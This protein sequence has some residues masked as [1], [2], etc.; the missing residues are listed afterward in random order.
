MTTTEISKKSGKGRSQ[1]VVSELTAFFTVKPGRADHLRAALDRFGHATDAVD[2]DTRLRIGLRELR[3]VIF[4]DD[5]RF[6]WATS[7]ETDWDPYI[8]DFITFVG[9]ATV[10]DFTQH[11]VEYPFPEGA[12]LTASNAE[13]KQILQANQTQ[14]TWFHEVFSARTMPEIFKA[15]KV[16]QAFQ[17]VL[18][19]PDAEQALRHPALTPLLELAA[20]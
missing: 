12:P 14:A 6:L 11:L 8:D 20:D 4:D 1:G 17:Q 2:P 9:T 16:A 7:F 5:R 3:L 15:A 19:D 13:I 18:D 10:V